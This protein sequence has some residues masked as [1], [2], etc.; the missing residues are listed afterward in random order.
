MKN[1][2][3]KNAVI[4]L[5]FG[6]IVIGSLVFF[7]DSSESRKA[8]LE[9]ELTLTNVENSPTQVLIKEISH[10][11]EV[12]VEVLNDAQASTPTRL[13]TPFASSLEG[14][15][16]DGQLKSDASGNLVID[17]EVRDFFDYFLNTVGEVSPEVALIEI[18]TIA[19]NS[20]PSSAVEQVMTVLSEYLLY[21]ETALEL[22]SQSMIPADQ[23]TKQ[24]Q[25]EM[26]E[27]TFEQ[28]KSIRRQT[29]SPETVAAFFELEEAYGEYTLAS[30]KVQ[31]DDA[32]SVDEKI[33]MQAFH[34]EKLPKIIQ[35]TEDSVIADNAKHKDVHEAILTSSSDDLK[36][37]LADL[38]YSEEATTEIIAYQNKQKNF[39]QRYQKYL[40]DKQQMSQSGLSEQDQSEQLKTLQNSYFQGE[41]ELSQAR[42]RDLSS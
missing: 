34:R 2:T 36:Q 27:S 19:E 20:L 15:D 3:K 30:I 17:L 37:K 12:P 32:L 28:M 24:Y 29:M 10:L 5:S 18:K 26:L 1:I 16:I 23:Q 42:V 6:A 4:Y 40:F 21:K 8:P 39:D 7:T 11:K 22:M 33:A 13:S 14:T 41:S 38:N 9:N 31:N 25:I 35:K